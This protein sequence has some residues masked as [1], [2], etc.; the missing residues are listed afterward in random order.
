MLVV[1]SILGKLLALLLILLLL[2]L[3]SPS[4]LSSSL[5]LLATR[6]AHSLNMQVAISH[7]W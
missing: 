7:V 5:V 1:I 2:L 6:E 4:S 3:L